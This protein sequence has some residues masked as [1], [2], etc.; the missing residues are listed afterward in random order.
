MGQM[1]PAQAAPALRGP[2]VKLS[3]GGTILC[4]NQAPEG[5]GWI[6]QVGNGACAHQG[7]PGG[8]LQ[9]GSWP[10]PRLKGSASDL[11]INRK[12]DKQYS[13]AL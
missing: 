5:P 1:A 7:P 9:W 6:P 12:R 4:L 3:G 11:V 8:I 10:R 13:T 2:E